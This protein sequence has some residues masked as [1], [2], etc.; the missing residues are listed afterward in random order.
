VALPLRSVGSASGVILSIS[1]GLSLFSISFIFSSG[2]HRVRK[3]EETELSSARSKRNFAKLKKVKSP[4]S[5]VIGSRSP[6]SVNFIIH[7]D[8]C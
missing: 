7:L 4:L 6:I 5:F 2:H 1:I 8:I 3:R